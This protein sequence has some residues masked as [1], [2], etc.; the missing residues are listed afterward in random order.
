MRTVIGKA[1]R[2][3]T[4]LAA[5]DRSVWL[6]ADVEA[7]NKEPVLL[8][9]KD[10]GLGGPVGPEEPG[11]ATVR[12]DDVLAADIRPQA[13]PGLDRVLSRREGLGRPIAGIGRGVLT[14]WAHERRGLGSRARRIM[15]GNRAC[16]STPAKTGS[17][18]RTT[19]STPVEN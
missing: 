18:Q 2:A 7:V 4:A 14:A 16:L 11:T 8:K 15:G 19:V 6:G 10:V 12:V 17:E 13:Q 1:A 5:A 9:E 3:A